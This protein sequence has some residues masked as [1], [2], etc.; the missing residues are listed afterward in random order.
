M[1]DLND[2]TA[3][4]AADPHGLH[5]HILNLPKQMEDA[6]AATDR[7][8]LP[9]SLSQIDRVVIIGMGGS[10]IGGSLLSA[11]MSPE[12]Q[13]PV[14]VS[15]DYDLPAFARGSNAL[16]IASSHSGNTEETLSAFDQ[17][18]SRGCHLIV[19]AA[20]GTLADRA[21]EFHLP[22]ITI[23]YQ[24]QPRAALGWSFAPL[25][26]IAS[27]LKWTHDLK[28][29]LDEAIA[30]LRSGNAQFSAE[31]P[32]MKNLAKR[33]AGQ[34][35]GRIVF[36]FGAGYFAEVARRWKDQ[37]NENA[38]HWAAFESLPEADHNLLAGLEFPDKFSNRVMALFL[39][40]S[41][42]HPRNA[43]RIDLTRKEFMMAG[44]NTDILTPRGES[45]LAQMLSLIQL[46]DFMSFYLALLNGAEPTQI[47]VMVEFK[48][49]M[50]D[51]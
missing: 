26:N 30:V 39:T 5:Q 13:L 36:V 43:K 23:D 20:G 11:V 45:P 22:L 19:L 44:C 8:E 37:F 7:V 51:G 42:D 14:L 49:R 18:R 29:D 41:R 34:L 9:Q 1:N 47:D 21:R 4:H 6:W 50:A 25:L 2:V 48:V 40:G 35:M 15:R 33:E 28:N 31:S 32:V 3:I 12:S 38:K 46:G 27:R 10:A 16:V 24:S 17:A